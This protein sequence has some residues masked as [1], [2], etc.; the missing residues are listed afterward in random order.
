[1][2]LKQLK[3]GPAKQARL[4]EAGIAT[5]EA[6]A[7]AD[8][9]AV[10]EKTGYPVAAVRQL[11]QQAAAL[12]MLTDAKSLGPASIPTFADSALEA[13]RAAYHTSSERLGTELRLAQEKVA[14]WQKDSQA[15]GAR[16]MEEAK[17]AEGR[18]RIAQATQSAARDAAT[19]LEAEGKVLAAKARDFQEKAPGY[20]AEARERTEKI[21]KDAETQIREV[22]ERAQA[23]MQSDVEK[24]KAATEKAQGVVKSEAAKARQTAQSIT[25]QAKSVVQGAKPERVVVKGS[26]APKA[27]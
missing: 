17:T 3:I 12:A 7:R 1:M 5:V 18:K 20:L 14:Q 6:L 4:K 25:V 21:L 9:S 8:E 11:K 16:L 26:Q 24:V 19:R 22:A 10:A 23:R 15:A 2:D 13:L 27:K